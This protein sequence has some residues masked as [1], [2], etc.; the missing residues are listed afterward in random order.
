MARFF[1]DRPIF[2]WVIALM[3]I[4]SGLISLRALPI[5]QYPNIAPP[6]VSITAVYPGASAKTV[7]EA[8]TTLI[9]REMN[10]AP[11]LLY[12]NASSGANVSQ[13]TV[14]FAQGTRMPTSLRSRFRIV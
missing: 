4:I 8:V 11:G 5:E 12:T 10:G 1:I 2:A 7:E 9:E 6:S 3:I 14:T 13:I